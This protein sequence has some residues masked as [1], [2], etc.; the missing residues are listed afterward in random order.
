MA[1]LNVTE[2]KVPKDADGTPFPTSDEAL[3]NILNTSGYEDRNTEAQTIERESGIIPAKSPAVENPVNTGDEAIKFAKQ[4]TFIDRQKQDLNPKIVEEK[5]EPEK[6]KDIFDEILN[7]KEVKKAQDGVETSPDTAAEIQFTQDKVNEMIA[8]AVLETENK[9]QDMKLAFDEF[10]KN[11]YEFYAKHSPYVL[12]KMDVVSYVNDKL[13]EEFGEDFQYNPQDV[14]IFGSPSNR[15]FKRQNELEAEANNYKN[16]AS[17]TLSEQEKQVESEKKE[18][19]QTVMKKYGFANEADF[20]QQV[21]NDLNQLTA[22]EVWE[23]L[24]QFKLVKAKLNL[25]QGNIKQPISKSF[26]VP[27]VGDINGSS[28]APPAKQA[29]DAGLENFISPQR[30]A[31]ASNGIIR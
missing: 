25:L 24:I 23:N 20:D 3:N 9:Y 31:E 4:D 8:A 13:K 30:M 12:Q 6:V 2:D 28:G 10:Q 29:I 14:A 17:N 26:S 22:K 18:F 7:P 11:P 1:V 19:K 27:G 16:T 5:I 15:Y 21:W